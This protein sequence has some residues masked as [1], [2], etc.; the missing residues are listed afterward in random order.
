MS[1]AARERRG[2]HDRAANVTLSPSAASTQ[3]DMAEGSAADPP[4]GRT[5]IYI[6]TT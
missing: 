4:F 3:Y 6:W 1:R 5:R 2:T